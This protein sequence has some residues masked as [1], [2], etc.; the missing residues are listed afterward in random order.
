MRVLVTGATGAQGGSVA[1]TLLARG[2]EVVALTRKPESSAAH[3]LARAGARV[4]AG[5]LA[6]RTALFRLIHEADAVFGLTNYWEHFGAEVTHGKNLVDACR[7]RRAVHLDLSTLASAAEASGGEISVPHLE[8]K[9]EIEAHARA[10]SVEPTFLH[11]AYYYENFLTWFAPRRDHGG[12][13][14]FGFPQGDAAL[15]AVSVADVG[16]VVASVLEEGSST[17]GRTIGVVGDELPCAQYAEAMS[18][19]VGESI[20]YRHVPREVFAQLGFP[21]AEDLAARF[22]FTRRFVGSRRADREETRR[23]NPGVSDFSAWATA[24][25]NA[26]REVCRGP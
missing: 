1:R 5:D 20:T 2:H 23:R 13:L 19:V 10:S 4:V 7:E 26:L 6:D 8:T 21:G 12:A 14:S 24:N 9:R 17:R 15:A 16:A 22:E 25:Q 18:R 3:A 11:V